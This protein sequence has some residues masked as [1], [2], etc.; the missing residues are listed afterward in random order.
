MKTLTVILEQHTPLIHFQHDQY[1]ATLRASEVKPKL[2]RFLL[3]KLK[4]D[5][6]IVIQSLAFCIEGTTIDQIK[7]IA[8]EYIF[9]KKMKWMNA[10]NKS[11]LYKMHINTKDENRVDLRMSDNA[12]PFMLCNMDKEGDEL[13]QFSYYT[14]IEL[15]IMAQ[16]E[17]LL[18]K[19]DCY[20]D[21]FF[22][23]TNFGNR[24]NK[25]FGSF[26]RKG[27]SKNDFQKDILKQ[28]P[29]NRIWV[30][31]I[32]NHVKDLNGFKSLFGK[33][34]HDYKELKSGLS[35]R[36]PKPSCLSRYFKSKDE[37]IIN[38]KEVIKCMVMNN[39]YINGYP[40]NTLYIRSCLGLTD[41]VK[42]TD[43]ME[44]KIKHL[45][46]DENDEIERYQSPITFKI[47]DNYIFVLANN[48]FNDIK[49]EV[50]EFSFVNANKVPVRSPVKLQT[51]GEFDLRLFLKKNLKNMGY[52][53]LVE[54]KR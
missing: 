3:G 38:E 49:D 5:S 2:D 42:L 44:I 22:A 7:D 43:A 33:I 11:F 4:K 31:N 51:P 46:Q 37:N 19:I 10:K 13:I 26:Y 12:F 18:S 20:I 15:K 21:E 30:K 8:F 28:Y 24:Q 34:E 47:F 50:F 52:I 14:E 23:I 32:D 1:G 48:T 36:R 25:G 35:G 53:N 45:F 54:M 41:G 40:Q 39:T 17:K 9:N 6:D 29:T 27:R 16:D